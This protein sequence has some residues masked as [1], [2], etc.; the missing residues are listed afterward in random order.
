[1]EHIINEA[2][3]IR[4][5]LPIYLATM[6]AL[7]DKLEVA[8]AKK[9]K[10]RDDKAAIKDMEAEVEAM[11]KEARVSEAL[12]T[13]LENAVMGRFGSIKGMLG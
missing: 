12:A 5:Q 3:N 8:K 7:E 10:D 4:N 11:K 6:Q 1:M 13:I 9:D 2:N